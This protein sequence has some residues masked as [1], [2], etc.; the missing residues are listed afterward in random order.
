MRIALLQL[1]ARLAD[2]EGNGR[3]LEAAYATAVAGGAE[4]VVAPEL[5]LV[6]YLAEDR[7][8]EPALVRRAEAEG[9]RLAALTGPAPLLFG[10]VSPAPPGPSQDSIRRQ[11]NA[12]LRR[13]FPRLDYIV[14]AKVTRTWP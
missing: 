12:Y 8:F 10:T 14:R 2:P 13:A 3:A 11:G 7:L 9:R 1:N 5:A 4:L 6:G